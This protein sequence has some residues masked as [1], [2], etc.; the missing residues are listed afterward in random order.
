MITVLLRKI[1][2]SLDESSINIILINVILSVAIENWFYND[3]PLTITISRVRLH[4]TNQTRRLKTYKMFLVI[5]FTWVLENHQRVFIKVWHKH[6]W[7]RDLLGDGKPLVIE[8][9]EDC[10]N[11]TRHYTCITFPNKRLVG[12]NNLLQWS[13]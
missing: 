11:I 8:I 7:E 4:Y 10:H 6:L 1:I 12:I 2:K 13:Q 5:S 9:V 3:S